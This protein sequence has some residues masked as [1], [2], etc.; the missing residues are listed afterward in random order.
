MGTYLPAER[1]QLAS[2]EAPPKFRPGSVTA[3]EISS[4]HEQFGERPDPGTVEGHLNA[5]EESAETRRYNK[6]MNELEA[7]D[8]NRQGRREGTLSKMLRFLSACI[9][10]KPI[11]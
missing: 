2:L 7:Q 10:K 8:A 5:K 4:P 6:R 3:L 1:T 9:R 11:R